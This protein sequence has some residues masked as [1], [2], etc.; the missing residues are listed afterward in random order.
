MRMGDGST[1]SN[2]PCLSS[3]ELT[4]MRFK[5]KERFL[6]RLFLIQA[7]LHRACPD[8]SPARSTQRK[9]VDRL[10]PV[11]GAGAASTAKP[12]GWRVRAIVNAHKALGEACVMS[13]DTNDHIA[14]TNRQR[15]DL[16]GAAEE[17]CLA[18]N[19]YGLVCTEWPNHDGWHRVELGGR[20]L[21]TWPQKESP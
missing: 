10:S 1:P 21:D 18:E 11:T 8:L 2:A 14:E 5:K 16:I 6:N 13:D 15:S 12:A 19:S 3:L 4:R 17:F 9:P 7:R 20:L